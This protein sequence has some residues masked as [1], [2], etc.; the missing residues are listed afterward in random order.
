MAA[1]FS[2]ETSKIEKFSKKIN[3]YAKGVLNQDILSR[4]LR[5]DM[6]I[7]LDRINN[8]LVEKLKNFEPT[9]LG[10]PSP[11]FLSS[12][13]EIIDARRVGRDLKHLKLRLRQNGYIFDSI[14]FGGGENYSKISA[15]TI[16]SIAYRIE[17]NEWNGR[18]NLQ[19]VIK[20]MKI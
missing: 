10:N 6:E 14:F 19:L 16:A 15:D 8:D 2:I 5:V 13:V 9:G 11:S 12:K 1:G 3:S 17:E 4:K 18:T 20:D 7:S